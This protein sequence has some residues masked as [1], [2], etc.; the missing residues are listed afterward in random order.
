MRRFLIAICALLL[1]PSSVMACYEDHKA[2][3]EWFDEPSSNW[4]KYGMGAHAAQRDGLM[5]VAVFAGG[6]GVLILLGVGIRTHLRAAR[7]AAA[8]TLEPAGL[9]LALANDGPPCEPLCV[10]AGLD[11]QDDVWASAEFR[12]VCD[13]SLTGVNFPVETFNCLV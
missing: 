4:I 1:T 3:A 5:D 2:G 6:S 13:L 8:E 11:S 9:P 7:R 10:R 12:D